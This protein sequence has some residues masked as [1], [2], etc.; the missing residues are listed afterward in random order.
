MNHY[1]IYSF[2]Y[3]ENKKN[4]SAT[5]IFC[6]GTELD[7]SE[8]QQ[9]LKDYYHH[10]YQTDKTIVIGGNYISDFAESIVSKKAHIFKYVPK[11]EADSFYENLH[12]LTFNEKGKLSESVHSELKPFTT[13]SNFEKNYINHGAQKIFIENGGLVESTGSHHHFVFPSGKHSDRFLRVANVLLLSSEIYF[14]AS[15][16]LKHLNSDFHKRIYC[17]TSSINSIAIALNDLVNR[18]ATETP[19][20]IYPINSFKSYE[21]LYD[22]SLNLKSNSLILIS[23]STSGGMVEYIL[24]Q[25]AEL[26]K[27]NLVILF[28]LENRKPSK[29]TVEQVLCNLTKTKDNPQGIATFITTDVEN[30]HLC[31]VNS[32]PVEVSGDVFLLEQPKVNSIRIN[33]EDVDL[34]VSSPFIN[35]FIAIKGESPILKV[36]YKET[37]EDT[38]KKY[39]LYI[40]YS[41]I[42]SNLDEPRL[43]KH[44]T[45]LNSYIDQHVPSNLKYI[46]CLSDES[47][48]KLG[49]YIRNRIKSNYVTECVPELVSRNEI[50]S[51]P[52]SLEGSILIVG[53]CISNGKNLLYL[54]RAFRNHK[55]R[56]VYFIGINRSPNPDT[57]SFLKSNL[58]YGTYGSENSSFVEVE[59]IHCSNLAEGNSW[60]IELEFLKTHI[61]NEDDQTVLKFLK[62]RKLEIESSYSVEKK[63]MSKQIFLPR[64]TSQTVKPL[65]IRRNSAFFNREDYAD[66]VTQADVYFTISYV[67]NKLRNSNTG[68]SLKQSMFVR[69]VISPENLNRFNDGIIQASILRNARVGELNYSIDEAL[70]RQATDILITI[71]KYCH[72]DQGEAILEFLYAIATEKMLLKKKHL[73]VLMNELPVSKNKLIKF[74]SK[75]IL[76]KIR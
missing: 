64:V 21:G 4:V 59:K 24:A 39:D 26:K 53:S 67:L 19:A 9:E 40:D 50:L 12:V 51:I 25:H 29:V 66:H 28:Y 33:A 37:G 3:K 20:K 23:A 48:H 55:L 47:S 57:Y 15:G 34:S 60:Q 14:I 54:S 61:N 71:F 42:I 74:Y 7:F 5:V 31:K 58:K 2:D 52:K 56:I 32:F 72:E 41:H 68:H 10:F 17:D 18:F 63:G 38:S 45:K 30:C 22:K 13:L 65:K 62:A 44:K 36:N 11:I 27:D 75:I 16:L 35:Q 46:L 43:K 49:E 69:N 73:E 8:L 1:Y 6:P 70:S 76:E